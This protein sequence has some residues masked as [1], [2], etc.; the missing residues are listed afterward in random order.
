[1]AQYPVEDEA[2]L[3]S[4]VNYL[5]SGP[6]GLGQNFQG[7]SA[8][9]PAYLTGTFR[10][11][12]TVSTTA[13]TNPPTWYQTPISITTASALTSS[14]TKNILIEFTPQ[15]QPPFAPGDSVFVSGVVD[16]LGNNNYNGTYG[17]GGNGVLLCTTS[18]VTLQT[19][20]DYTYGTY[21][22]GGTITKDYRNYDASTDANAR[23]TVS[24]PGDIVFISSQLALT[25]GVDCTTASNFDVIVK[26]NRYTGSVDTESPGAVDYL[27]NFDG[28][29]S[30]QIT[31]I[32]TNTTST[33]FC[34]QNIFTTVLDQPSFGYYWYICDVNF[35]TVGL[36]T[37]GGLQYDS[38]TP[39]GTR[40]LTTG[41]ATFT[42]IS[43]T[44]VT[45]SGSGGVVD[46]TLY[47]A[48]TTSTAYTFSQIL[49]VITTKGN[50][51]NA[52]DILTVPGTSLGG[53]SP[54]ND[55]TLTITSVQDPGDALPNVLTV[56]LRSLTAQVIK[57]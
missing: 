55:L 15:A 2:G 1:M 51:Y 48:V 45:G 3:Y 5:L 21:V 8:Y 52:G 57:Q 41:T 28:T 42:G 40:A 6:A 56:G 39:T 23:V 14:T 16:S 37:P 10:A 26:I 11:P 24:G 13:T 18:T 30:E 25:V 35:A 36:T 9:K 27:F 32:S 20:I 44:T 17:G 43:P 50:G 12:F 33:I 47:G 53:A 4:A 19:S 22:S 7:F 38:F 49:T 34:G 29:V 31:S 54:A 46:I